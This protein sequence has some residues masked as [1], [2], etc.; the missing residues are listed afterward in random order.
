M[1]IDNAEFDFRSPHEVLIDQRSAEIMAEI[2]A[3]AESA[4]RS[5]GQL[6]RIDHFRRRCQTTRNDK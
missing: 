6:T 4:R 5:I 2:K 3:M 1:K